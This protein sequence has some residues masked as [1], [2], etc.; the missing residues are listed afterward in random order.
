MPEA[1]ALVIVT[2]PPAAGKT[3]LARRLAADAGLLL[4]SRD[5][6]KEALFDA[7][8][9]SDLAWSRRLGGASYELLYVVLESALRAGCACLAESNF[10]AQFATPR[11]RALMGR[12]PFRPLQIALR[13]DPAALAL[14]MRARVESGERHPGHHDR[15]ELGALDPATLRDSIPPVDIGGELL[16]VDTTDFGAV[17][18]GGLLARVLAHRG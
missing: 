6:L 11:L 14:R 18:Y 5:A 8:G 12:L 15:H 1:P 10:D 13:A 16:V 4:I 17:D 9:A 3:A 2:G 7:L